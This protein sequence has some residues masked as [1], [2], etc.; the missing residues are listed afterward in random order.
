MT[1]PEMVYRMRCQRVTQEALKKEADVP[2]GIYEYRFIV[3]GL[4]KNDP[5]CD[6]YHLNRYGSHNCILTVAR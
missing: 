4:W 3:D 6:Q 1:F 5:A 2:P